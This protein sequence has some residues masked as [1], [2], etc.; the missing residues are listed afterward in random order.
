MDVAP[1]ENAADGF[2]VILGL[3]LAGLAASALLGMEPLAENRGNIPFA[4][5]QFVMLL[6]GLFLVR[7]GLA[8]LKTPGETR[9]ASPQA[10]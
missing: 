5:V 9:G 1:S 6:T 8:R 7:E 3:A 2:L 4:A 10:P